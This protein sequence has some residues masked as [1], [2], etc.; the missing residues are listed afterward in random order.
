[1]PRL[2]VLPVNADLGLASG[3]GQLICIEI[4]HHRAK[5]R[6]PVPQF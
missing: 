1:M 2:E 4:R 5:V 3:A 6:A